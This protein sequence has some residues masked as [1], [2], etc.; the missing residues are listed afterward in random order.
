MCASWMCVVAVFSETAFG[1][2]AHLLLC[3]EN[4]TADPHR[5]A[6]GHLAAPALNHAALVWRNCIFK[7]VFTSSKY[8]RHPVIKRKVSVKM[9]NFFFDG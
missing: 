8:L 2:S 6:R 3:E 9:V 7:A 1:L 5:P 4:M